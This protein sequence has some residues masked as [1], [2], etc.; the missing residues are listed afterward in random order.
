MNIN[1]NLVYTPILK[2][3]KAE[4]LALKD[5]T[6]VQKK[7]INPLIQLVSKTSSTTNPDGTK[8]YFERPE[9][10]ILK[11]ALDEMKDLFDFP[12]VY[13]DPRPLYP[14]NNNDLIKKVSQI[15]TS[16]FGNNIVP[17]IN[18]ENFKDTFDEQT[19]AFF[20]QQGI[21]LRVLKDH[22]HDNFFDEIDLLLQKIGLNRDKVDF[23]MDYKITDSNC[24]ESIITNIKK[25]KKIDEWRSLYFSSGAFRKD[26][27]GLKPGNHNQIRADW[28]LWKALIN[29]ISKVRLI[30]YSDYTI[31]Y[32]IYEPVNNPNT[33]Y[34][35]RYTIKEKWIIMKGQARNAK[36]NAGDL[37]YYAHAKTLVENGDFCG[38]KCCK[39]DSYVLKISQNPNQAKGNST[40]WLQVG[41]NHHMSLTLR[42]ISNLN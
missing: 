6:D 5:L 14:Q 34:S 1:N 21:C 40:T 32:P 13:F 41:I 33:S 18:I 2:W 7:S 25:D 27:V 26:L 10:E 38:E 8:N 23:L 36:N 3:K 35:F 12:K 39:G 15:S 9:K 31:Q 19:R 22:L 11:E 4:K 16:M 28:L 20:S 24:L 29:Q 30:N 37:Q 17:V 42:Q